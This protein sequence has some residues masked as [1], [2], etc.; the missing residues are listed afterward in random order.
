MCIYEQ[1]PR[2]YS[3]KLLKKYIF[4]CHKRAN[5]SGESEQLYRNYIYSNFILLSS[6]RIAHIMFY[7]HRACRI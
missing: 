6:A 5:K 7:A 1:I 4:E 3:R 2:L